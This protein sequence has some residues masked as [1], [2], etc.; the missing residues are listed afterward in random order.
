MERLTS[1][2]TV[3]SAGAGPARRDRC[4]RPITSGEARHGPQCGASGLEHHES[5]NRAERRHLG[6]TYGE[7]RQLG[8]LAHDSAPCE[9]MSYR[10][11]LRGGLR[12]S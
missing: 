8:G 5:E 2:V 1:W 10:G 6:R 7:R 4:R 3:A 11:S 12:I 9:F